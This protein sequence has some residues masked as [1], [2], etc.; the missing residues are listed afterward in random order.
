M[1]GIK[2]EPEWQT[3]RVRP[4]TKRGLDNLKLHHKESYNEVIGRLLIAKKK[5][6][7]GL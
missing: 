3:V 2:K 7:D 1:K 4:D 5:W 6:W